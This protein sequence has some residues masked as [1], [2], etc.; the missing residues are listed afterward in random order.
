MADLIQLLEN[1]ARGHIG[2]VG[3]GNV[4]AGDDALGVRLAEQVARCG[5]RW[6]PGR[7]RILQAGM[8]PER[9]M[10]ELLDGGFA[11]V[12]FL[13]AVDCGAAPGSVVCLD[14]A[15]IAGR[16]PQVST[17]RISL[18]LL[19]QCLVSQAGS[20]VWL[21]G[22]QP[23][24]QNLGGENRSLSA[25]VQRSLER[26]SDLLVGALWPAQEAGATARSVSANRMI[27]GRD[28]SRQREEVSC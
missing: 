28:E 3:V 19:A 26:L 14:A 20:R 17:H 15:E 6:A 12:V 5:S 16:F 10:A 8:R 4:D 21:L 22:I 11:Q 2:L 1:C 24:A 9:H 13:D 27:A 25:P 18:G 23:A 7:V